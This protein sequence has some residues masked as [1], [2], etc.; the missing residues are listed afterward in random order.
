[1]S[2]NLVDIKTAL[3]SMI[4]IQSKLIS[5]LKFHRLCIDTLSGDFNNYYLKD[6]I[7]DILI[8]K[9]SDFFNKN[10]INLK[11]NSLSNEYVKGENITEI[12]RNVLL[13]QGYSSSQSNID[14]SNYY[15]KIDIDLMLDRYITD[16][17]LNYQINKIKNDLLNVDYISKT[18]YTKDQTELLIAEILSNYYDDEEIEDYI[19]NKLKSLYNNPENFI[20]FDPIFQSL[21]GQFQLKSDA[22]SGNYNDLYNKPNIPTKLSEFQN[23]V[24][25]TTSYT[26]ESDPVFRSVSGQFQ[27]KSDAFSGSYNDLTNKP[28]IPIIDTI[29]F[30]VPEISGSEYVHFKIEFSNS[31][32]FS[33]S[34]IT[35]V[36]DSSN[37]D[38]SLIDENNN[39]IT[40]LKVF[41][42]TEMTEF[43]VNGITSVY[44][45]EVIKL[46]ITNFS[47]KYYR[48]QWLYGDTSDESGDLIPGR[49]GFGQLNAI[50]NVFD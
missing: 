17:T 16:D 49:M 30:K 37:V 28:N 26:Q 8:E 10:E 4:D 42:G 2:N 45:R 47:G 25:F 5:R 13:N 12:V 6:E 1:M 22:F 7:N 36:F 39:V 44:S 23:D 43:P 29:I 18:F 48:Y 40:C 21:S 34:D 32:K 14:L 15:N 24:G 11:F 27:L 50:M 46:N 3:S 33:N 20:E 9:C 35:S 19:N 38:S 41:T 31:D